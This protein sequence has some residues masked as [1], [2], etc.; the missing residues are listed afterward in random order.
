MHIPSE[1]DPLIG[2]ARRSKPFYRARPLWIVPF[3]ITAALVRG[4][5]AAPRIEVFTQLAC[6]QIHPHPYNHTVSA[7]SADSLS[8]HGAPSAPNLPPLWISLEEGEE[9]PR[10]LPSRQCMNDPAVQGYAARLQTTMITTMGLLSVLSTGWWGHFGERFGRT[11]VLAI[12]TLGLFLTDM[13]FILVSTPGSPLASHGHK[14]LL[15]SPIIEGSLGGWS[16]L[17]SVTNAYISDCTSSGSRASVFSRFAGV[18]FFGFSMGPALAGWLIRN[19]IGLAPD[20]ETSV[21][22][23][24][25]IACLCSF[26]NVLFTLFVVPESLSADKRAAAQAS[27]R[28]QHSAKGKGRA[29]SGSA[30]LADNEGAST[31]EERDEAY[32]DV[33][34]IRTFLSPMALFYPVKLTDASTNKTARD[35]SLTF[36]GM[37]LFATT[38]ATGIFQI[39]YLYADHVYSL[40]AEKLSYYISFMGGSRAVFMLALLPLFIST[41]KP[42]SKNAGKSTPGKPT[43][44]HLGREIGFDLLVSR[45][46]VMID[47]I[48]NVLVVM[49]PSPTYKVHQL[50]TDSV[51]SSASAPTPAS[52][53][54]LALFVMASGLGCMGSGVIPAV[55]SLALLIVQARTLVSGGEVTQG[56]GGEGVGKIFGAFA[57]LQATGQM[58]LGPMMFGLI[59]SSTV[60]TYPKAVFA[61]AACVLVFGLVC[62]LLAQSPL[63]TFKKAKRRLADEEEAARGRSRV[64]KD[65]WN[66]DSA[67]SSSGSSGSSAGPSSL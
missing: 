65:V 3:A 6:A 19:K 26:L 13:T 30:P 53:H 48:S 61:V 25:Y 21:A 22:P 1:T 28:V 16:T 56:K 32:A 23:V 38:L 46:S 35:W 5:T 59:Y 54:S 39:K 24:F 51:S 8:F 36:M 7:T 2:P 43:K 29:L 64:S 9:D 42:K 40:G 10:H 11:K 17:Q 60:A 41:F 63:Q 57:V 20:A 37:G 34:V 4:M 15:I 62:L 31:Q 44:A 27:Y 52:S 66:I 12:A 50:F 14:L 33:G 67:P 58:I 47:I 45:L 18:F 55:Q 49:T